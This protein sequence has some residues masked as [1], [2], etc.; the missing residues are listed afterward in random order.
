MEIMWKKSKYLTKNFKIIEFNIIYYL[1]ESEQILINKI[2]MCWNKKIKKFVNLHKII[3]NYDVLI[4]AFKKVVKIKRSFFIQKNYKTAQKKVWKIFQFLKNNFWKLKVFKRIFITKKLK[5]LKSLPVF[6]FYDNLI[7]TIIKTILNFIFE[8]VKGL[9]LF[10]K[11]VR[12]FHNANHTFSLF[13]NFHSA[14][15]S[16][17]T[18]KITPWIIQSNIINSYKDIKKQKLIAIIK[19]SVVDQL[20]IGMLFFISLKYII[21]CNN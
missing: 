13:K 9:N 6:T 11:N 1:N 15:N 21:Y 8:K 14:L 18:W 17:L 20:L 4:F 19:K 16:I 12:Y 2:R 7:I 10:L 5:N 3:F